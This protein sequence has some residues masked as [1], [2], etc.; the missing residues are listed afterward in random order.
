MVVVNSDFLA[1]FLTNVRA[2]FGTSLADFDKELGLYALVSS[3]IQSDTDTEQY[4]WMGE[5]PRMSL[6]TDE[7]K[8]F[9]LGKFNYAIQNL[10]FEATIG[11]NRDT[12]EDDKYGMISPRI[13]GLAR[14]A[15]L[16]YNE[17]VFSALDDG[18]A[19]NAY[20]GLKF[21]VD[22]RVIGESANIN[23]IL[24]GSY[25]ADVAE[26]RAAIKAGVARMRKFQDDRGVPMNL[27][28]DTI[29]CSADMEMLIRE[30]LLPA[31]A[32]TQR[33]E[34]GMFPQANQIIST[35]WIDNDELDWYLLCTKA[36]LKPIIL[37][38]RKKP[39]LVAADD[40]KTE[41]AFMKN[42]FYYG[43]DDRFNVGYADPRT[44]I[45]VVDA[46]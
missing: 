7:R 26:I 2:I 25:S 3:A 40:P 30:A 22:T 13:K 33:P 4:G 1:A 43:V 8:V 46:P 29:V 37:Q 41:A 6:W 23:N 31:V 12:F 5:A 17:K 20:D 42:I 32:G 35:P 44:A 34:A 39:E 36:E 28:P 19:A 18:A 11:V 10:H 27:V 15:I 16:F 21:F 45:M 38:D 24:S 14:R 9:G